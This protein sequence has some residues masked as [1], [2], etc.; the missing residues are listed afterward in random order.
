LDQWDQESAGFQRTQEVVSAAGFNRDSAR[1]K[2][3]AAL[4]DLSC[5]TMQWLPL[6]K[7]YFREDPS[8]LEPI[9]QL[10]AGR[11][12]RGA[13]AQVDMDLETA[14]QEVGSEWAPTET[15][16]LQKSVAF[17][18]FMFFNRVSCGNAGR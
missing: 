15:D 11:L 14:W 6:A 4:R 3:G 17:I 16:T 5:R 9:G 10:K 2:L 1:A 12:R 13:I 8:M 18:G 7:F